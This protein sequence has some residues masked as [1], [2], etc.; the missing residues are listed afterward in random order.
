MPREYTILVRSVRKIADAVAARGVGAGELYRAVGLDPALLDDPDNR[1]PFAQFVALYE[2]GARL[3]GDDAFGLHVGEEASPELFDVLGYVLANSATLRESL[4]RLVRYH[5]IWSGGADFSL[6]VA[7]ERARLA[8]DY[9]GPLDGPRRHDAEMTLSI[10]VC[11]SRRVTGVDW[12]P[13]EVCFRHPRPESTAEHERIF[14]APVRF[15]RA[16]NVLSFDRAVLDL[17]LTKADPGLCDILDRQARELLAKMPRP[18]HFA[19]RV[20]EAIREALSGGDPRLETVAQRLGLSARTLQRK[21]REEG[22]S[23]QDLLDEVRCDLSKSYLRG[24]ELAVCEVA[25]LLGFSEPS[26]FHRA[27]RRWTGTT[28]RAFRAARAG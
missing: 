23:H 16:T 6:E 13:R 1:I 14:R 12:A 18:D 5:S 20:R 26:A 25:Y 2:E 9:L 15:G 27:F 19:E 22:A 8:Y 21:L 11:F 28:P 24:R 7:G 3:T 4:A 17:P 10:A